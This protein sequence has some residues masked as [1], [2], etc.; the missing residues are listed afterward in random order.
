MLK[1]PEHLRAPR[2]CSLT[3]QPMFEGWCI[4]DGAMYIKDMDDALAHVISEGWE[5]LEQ[6]Y[7]DDYMYWTDWYEIDEEDWDEV[8]AEAIINSLIADASSILKYVD[9]ADAKRMY[10]TMLNEYK[11]PS[12]NQQ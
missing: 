2:Y 12:F 7:E 9:D 10:V 5:N 8:P 11:Q 3:H 6:A 4:A 1:F